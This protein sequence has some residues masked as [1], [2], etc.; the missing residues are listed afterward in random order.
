[1]VRFSDTSFG[2]SIVQ[3]YDHTIYL[4]G[5]IILLL[6]I[7]IMSLYMG[8]ISKATAG[9]LLGVSIAASLLTIIYIVWKMMTLSKQVAA[10]STSG[11]G[12]M[13]FKQGVQLIG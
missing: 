4:V 11:F 9:S 13:L 3:I 10:A 7:I 5:T 12:T 2:G 1:M 8:I 6:I